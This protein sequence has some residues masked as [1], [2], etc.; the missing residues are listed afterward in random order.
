M[1]SFPLFTVCQEDLH[2]IAPSEFKHRAEPSIFFHF[3]ESLSLEKA[4][5]EKHNWTAIVPPTCLPRIRSTN[6]TIVRFNTPSGFKTA[7]GDVWM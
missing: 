3:P 2:S 4:I 6:G 5:H 1:P 7:S